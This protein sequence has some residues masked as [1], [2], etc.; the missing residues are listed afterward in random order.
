MAFKKA[1][2][3][4]GGRVL[5]GDMDSLA[6]ALYLADEPV[7]LPPVSGDE[8]IE[9]LKGVVERYRV[10]LIVPTID[11][12]LPFLAAGQEEFLR[13]G[14]RVLI[15]HPDC[16]QV[17]T[18]KWKAVCSF[19]DYGV[20]VPISRTADTLSADEVSEL[21]DDLFVKPRNGSAS[22]HTYQC[23]RGELA[24]ILPLVPNAIIQEYLPY[25]E[26][27]IDALIDFDGAVIHF[28]PRRR[29]RT[30][31]GESI[32]GVTIIDSEVNAWLL[33]VLQVV[34]ELGGRGPMTLQ[35]FLSPDGP[36]L[37]EINP[38]FGGGFPL[39]LAAGGDYPEWI[40]QMLEGKKIE[41][42][43]GLYRGNLYM[44]RYYSELI[45]EE[46]VWVVS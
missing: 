3:A 17:L 7:C 2:G 44:T 24:E 18:D 41:P 27:T 21:P 38:R 11:T 10:G 25:P 37:S 40:I 46:P 9:F 39:A 43:I 4:R 45:I 15:S 42:R 19:S 28:V 12:E 5:A 14:C 33:R 36:I 22:M 34:S 31:G 20:R 29:I 13:L 16:V 8:Y 6:P 23:T 1:A 32:Q 30:V 35:A 26:I